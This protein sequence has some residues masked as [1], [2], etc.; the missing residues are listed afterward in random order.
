MSGWD[1]VY[2]VITDMMNEAYEAGQTD[3]RRALEKK[4][5]CFEHNESFSKEEIK[6]YLKEIGGEQ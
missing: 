6:S 2:G 5:D 4:L 1:V 3:L